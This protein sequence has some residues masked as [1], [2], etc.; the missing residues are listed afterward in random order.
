MASF[1]VQQRCPMNPMSL[2]TLPVDALRDAQH[3]Q[4]PMSSCAERSERRV[5][6]VLVG[7][8]LAVAAVAPWF[9]V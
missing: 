2:L 3:L 4:E 6:A 8:V 5:A 1:G 9:L 7:V